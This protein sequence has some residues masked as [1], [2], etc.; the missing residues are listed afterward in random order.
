MC[1]NMLYVNYVYKCIYIQ[2][3]DWARY[4]YEE[5]EALKVKYKEEFL[6]VHLPN[7]LSKFNS[8]LEK[9]KHKDFLVCQELTWADVFIA[10]KMDRMQ[11]TTG[12]EVL[13]SYDAVKKFKDTVFNF[14][15]I[16]EYLKHHTVNI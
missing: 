12:Q 2:F 9:K 7:C 1:K 16:Q 4:F 14:P 15:K 5:D 8:L 6:A 13:D 3:P 10:T 11:K